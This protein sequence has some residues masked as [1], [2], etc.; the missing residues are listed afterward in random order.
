MR[1]DVK[2]IEL[3]SVD[4]SGD[5]R[6]TARPVTGVR[7]TETE[8]LLEELLVES[9]DLLIDGLSLVGRQLPTDGGPLDLIGVDQD[10][11]LVIFELK[12]GTLTRDAVAQ[13]LDYASDLAQWDPEHFARLIEQHSGR[14]GI[15][16]IED[17]DDWYA[18]EYST[19]PDLLDEP[20]KMVLVGLGVD[21]RATRIVNFLADSGI[22]IQ[23]LTYHAF[24]SNGQLF[25]ARQV[26]TVEPA[27]RRSKAGGGTKQERRRALLDSAE[28]LG[29]RD[30]LERVAEYIDEKMPCYRWPAKTAFS[31]SLHEQTAEGRPTQRTY[32]TLWLNQDRRG[33]V[34]LT[35]PPRVV[36]AVPA[37]VDDLLRSVESAR[38][39]DSNSTPIELD[40]DAASWPSVREPVGRLLEAIVR[41]WKA[42]HEEQ[43]EGAETEPATAL[44]SSSTE[45]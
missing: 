4:E 29:S 37:E 26:E 18:R 1:G 42:P 27:D 45:A 36:E 41:S 35:F 15:D 13:I 38:R 6:G 20:P 32:A 2:K 24:K 7:S 19:A 23:L 31:F 11:R 22:E 34:K 9:P 21:E 33:A 43:D 17:F 44:P 39:T 16:A 14:N 28:E 25:L 30:L 3:W 10:G 40:I 8:E 5:G 12:R